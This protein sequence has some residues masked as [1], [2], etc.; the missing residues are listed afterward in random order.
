M[1]RQEAAAQ[2]KSTPDWIE[3]A[4]VWRPRNRSPRLGI[5]MKRILLP[6]SAALLGLA[7]CNDK[8]S[9]DNSQVQYVTREGRKFEVRVAP[10][11]TPNEY[12]LMVVR[13]TLVIDPDPELERERGWAV[14]RDV[15]QQT[16]KGGRSQVL[17]DNLVDNVNLFTRF[18]CL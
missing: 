7:A 6:L 8:A 4:V 13:A 9:L 3:F 12:R 1:R 18:R 17:E 16:C 5:A 11:G 2:D 14:A 15:I 10:T